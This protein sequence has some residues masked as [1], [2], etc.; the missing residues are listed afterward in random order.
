VFILYDM[1]NRDCS[2]KASAGELSVEDSGVA[3]T[4]TEYVDAIAR[5]LRARP[6]QRVVLVLEP[7]SLANLATNLEVPKCKASEQA[8]KDSVAYAITALST[9]NAHPRWAASR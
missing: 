4:K 8:Y 2:A 9:P 1:P 7:D 6:A 5:Q 3:R